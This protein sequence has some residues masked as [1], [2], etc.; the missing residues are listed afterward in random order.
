MYSLPAREMRIDERM[1]LAEFRDVAVG[2]DGDVAVVDFV[3]GVSFDQSRH[4]DDAEL[5]GDLRQFL[6]R[7]AI[8]HRL[9]DV[10][11]LLLGEPLNPGVARNTALVKADDLGTLVDRATRQVSNAAQVVS[12]IVVSVLELGGGNADVSH[13]VNS[14]EWCVRYSRFCGSLLM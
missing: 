11:Q 10:E 2:P 9:G 13:V 5:G 3:L 14:C 7:R 4:H 8:R 6:D 12:R 1:Q